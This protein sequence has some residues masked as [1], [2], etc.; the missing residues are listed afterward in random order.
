MTIING[1]K[2][3]SHTVGFEVITA[4]AMKSSVLWVLTPRSPEYG[5]HGRRTFSQFILSNQDTDGRKYVQCLY[6]HY[7]M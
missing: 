2:I 1:Y 4:V 6:C 3:S 7:R 5:A